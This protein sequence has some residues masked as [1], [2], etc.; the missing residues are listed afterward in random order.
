MTVT[1]PVLSPKIFI[2]YPPVITLSF[3]QE[4]FGGSLKM[5]TEENLL[6]KLRKAEIA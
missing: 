1:V 2:Q 5:L 6:F 4:T 3:R